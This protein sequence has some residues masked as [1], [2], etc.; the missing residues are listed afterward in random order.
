[1]DPSPLE[2]LFGNRTAALLM[3]YLYHYGEAYARGA[4]GD[5]G[6]AVSAVQRQLDKFETAGLLVSRRVGKTRLYAFNPRQPAAAKLKDLVRVYYE[7]MTI[8]ERERVFA[9]RRRPRRK[10][11]PIL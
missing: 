8:A 7:A 6:L 11:K 9:T 2:A 3:L 1:M 4:A 5:L 10:G